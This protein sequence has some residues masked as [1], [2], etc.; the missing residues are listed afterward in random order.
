VPP[1]YRER[2]LP[3]RGFRE[4]IKIPTEVIVG[5]PIYDVRILSDMSHDRPRFADALRPAILAEDSDAP[6]KRRLDG[7]GERTG[8]A[9]LE[10]NERCRGVAGFKL[11]HT[12]F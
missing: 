2:P 5:R 4:T 11:K 1:R 3:E 6:G 9:V 10:F 8:R 7:G 12:R